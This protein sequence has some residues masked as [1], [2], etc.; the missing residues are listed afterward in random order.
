MTLLEPLVGQTLT[1][2]IYDYIHNHIQKICKDSFDS[3]FIWNLEKVIKNINQSIITVQF[4]CLSVAFKKPSM[5][6]L[7]AIPCLLIEAICPIY[8]SN[9]NWNCKACFT[10]IDRFCHKLQLIFFHLFVYF[11]GCRMWYYLG[12]RKY[13]VMTH[14]HL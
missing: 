5:D 9:S 2:L 14:Q 11:S 3:Y 8:D 13:I 1:N 4:V 7:N 10:L 12:W 6:R